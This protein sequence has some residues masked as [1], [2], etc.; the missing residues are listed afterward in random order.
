MLDINTL[1]HPD[2]NPRK[3]SEHDKKELTK[4]LE[5]FECVEPAV[6][7]SHKSRENVIVGGNQRIKVAKE[8]G[9][10]KFPCVV[11]DLN[12]KKEKE[13]N[14]RLNKNQGEWDWEILDDMFEKDELFDAGFLANE[15]EKILDYE[16]PNKNADPN[17]SGDDENDY[18]EITLTFH[19]VEA[20]LVK[21]ELDEL[22]QKIDT[23]SYKEA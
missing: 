17:Y 6:V 18:T 14:I 3:I 8:L 13:L 20:G 11:V 5:R 15:F 1:V 10:E 23:L 9:W 16:E 4:S 7:N 22:I 21:A 19:E 2:Y 12:L